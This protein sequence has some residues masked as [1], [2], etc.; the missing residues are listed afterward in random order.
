MK[1]NNMPHKKLFTILCF[2]LLL[3]LSVTC[4]AI[5]RST[6]WTIYL[7]QDKHLDYG[8]CGSTTEVELR[9]AALLDYYLDAALQKKVRWNLDCTLWDEVYHRHRGR[10]G[11]ERLHEAIR[12]GRIG[13]AV[14]VAAIVT[15]KPFLGN[16]AFQ[17]LCARIDLGAADVPRKT[18]GFFGKVNGRGHVVEGGVRIEQH[19]V[20]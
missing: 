7:A 13:Y 8:W 3:T 4:Q 19:E 17:K 1:D 5:E 20:E 12:N 18:R 14:P 15:C 2:S 11:R 10:E 9:M 16:K 6:K